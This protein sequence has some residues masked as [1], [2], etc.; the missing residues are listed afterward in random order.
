MPR[1]IDSGDVISFV[2]FAVLMRPDAV[3]AAG[4]MNKNQIIFLRVNILRIGPSG[5]LR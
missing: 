3:I 4:A 2:Q 5:N 1:K